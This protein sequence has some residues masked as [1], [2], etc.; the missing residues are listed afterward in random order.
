[1]NT[2][3]RNG[4]SI[5]RVKNSSGVIGGRI[6]YD[7]RSAGSRNK[8]LG[9]LVDAGAPAN[10]AVA[11][12]GTAGGW[13]ARSPA[14]TRSSRNGSVITCC[15]ERVYESKRYDASDE[16]ATCS[17]DN[18]RAEVMEEVTE[19]DADRWEMLARRNTS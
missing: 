7:K 12:A 8:V 3:N 18:D 10:A 6:T 1:M 14:F 9:G 17:V 16:G 4:S 2:C 15:T 13:T 11:A 5:N 19:A